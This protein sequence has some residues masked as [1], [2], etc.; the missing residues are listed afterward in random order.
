MIKKILIVI[1]CLC[2]LV[3]AGCKAKDIKQDNA[4][5]RI[6]LMPDMVSIPYIIGENEKTFEKYGVNIQISVFKSAGDRDAALQA[7]ALDAVSADI[8]AAYFYKEGGLDLKITSA[9]DILCMIVANP[10]VNVKSVDDLNQKTIGISYNTI[11]EYFVDAAINDVN[12]QKVS[13]PAIPVRIEMLKA[14]EIDA[15]ALPEPLGTS[16]IIDGA[17]KV[18]TS[19]DIG[20]NLGVLLFKQDFINDNKSLIEN[21]YLAL[22]EVN[23]NIDNEK[24]LEYEDELIEKLLFPK[25]VFGV[26]DIKNLN[27]TSLPE[28]EDLISAQIWLKEKGL[29]EKTFEYDDMV[30]HIDKSY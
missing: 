19:S 18:I 9:T 16:A 11:M 1:L 3:F 22:D 21:F 2:P 5:I 15:A 28:Q 24:F 12:D 30:Y 8:L 20:V 13:V 29:I 6:G 27:K 23:E 25:N 14:G 17:N 7:G 26:M 4:T 10:I